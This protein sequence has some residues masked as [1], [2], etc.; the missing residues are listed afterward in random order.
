M[1]QDRRVVT[2]EIGGEDIFAHDE[3]ALGRVMG[4]SALD[5]AAAKLLADLF[6]V[7]VGLQELCIVWGGLSDEDCVELARGLKALTCLQGLQISSAT[8]LS[9]HGAHKH[10]SSRCEMRLSCEVST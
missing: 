5:S 1:V 4:P 3:G 6:C 2:R 10:C 8:L 9:E 7:L